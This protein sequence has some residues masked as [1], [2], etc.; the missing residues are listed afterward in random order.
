MNIYEIECAGWRARVKAAS[1]PAAISRGLVIILRG[2][3]GPVFNSKKNDSIMVRARV[4]MR[5]I[6]KGTPV[7]PWD[8]DRK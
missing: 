8:E 4:M 6:P 1:W 5:N 7:P 2:K 3:E